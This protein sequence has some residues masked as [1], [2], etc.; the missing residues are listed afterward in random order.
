MSTT[1]AGDARLR[2]AFDG[3]RERGSRA[4]LMPYLMGGFPTVADSLA[5]GQMPALI[6]TT[7]T[8]AMA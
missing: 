4:A 7:N 2:A 1:V 3:A 6:P 8:S 5:I